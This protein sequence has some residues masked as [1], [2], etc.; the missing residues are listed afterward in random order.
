MDITNVKKLIELCCDD[1]FKKNYIQNNTTLKKNKWLV[2]SDFIEFYYL[3]D[4]INNDIKKINTNYQCSSFIN[5][6]VYE[7]GDYFNPH[8]DAQYSIYDDKHPTVLS[9]GYLLNDEFEGGDFLIEGIPLNAKIGELFT[10]SRNIVHEIT[11]VTKGMR[12]SLH[13]AV[14]TNE[15]ITTLI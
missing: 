6:L 4:V 8:T 9:G 2:L 5:L 12:Y 13:F 1:N 7:V 14:D 11:P 3:R 15:T 10:F